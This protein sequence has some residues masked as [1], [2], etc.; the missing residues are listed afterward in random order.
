MD[1]LIPNKCWTPSRKHSIEEVNCKKNV[2]EKES[3]LEIAERE[4]REAMEAMA[5]ARAKK[6][7]LTANAHIARL[8]SERDEVFALE[9][10]KYEADIVRVS[11]LRDGVIA[12]RSSLKAGELD[13]E[14]TAA[15]VAR[16]S[17]FVVTDRQALPV[18]RVRP[19]GAKRVRKVVHRPP[20]C[21]LITSRLNF[22]WEGKTC[23]TD[24]GKE[25]HE[26]DGTVFRSLNSWTETLIER[27]GGGGRK[28]SV[29]E[30]VSVQNNT[31]GKWKKWGEVYTEDCT[32]LQF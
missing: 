9:Q 20:L 16:A 1:T 2:F 31:T 27:G 5:R 24:N 8:R 21:S 15:T 28:V 30:V 10:A 26:P 7:Q 32:S 11:A 6:A 19:E 29:Y 17:D 13:T 3:D 12:K 14:L 23:Y 22:K 18:A 25:F 4:E